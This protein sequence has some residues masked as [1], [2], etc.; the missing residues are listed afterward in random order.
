MEIAVFGGGCFWCTEAVFQRLKGVISVVSGYA[1]GYK[2]NP[3]YQEVSYEETGHAE[4]VKIEFDPS[5]ISY[6]QLLEVFFYVHDPTTLNQQGN[7]VGT[8]YRSIIL[9]TSDEHKRQAE[10]TLKTMQNKYNQQNIPKRVVTEIKP[11]T[12][13]YA[14]EEYHQQYFENNPNQP[15]CQLI[16]GPKLEHFEMMFSNLLKK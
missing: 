16:I 13:F 10:L 6:T 5:I 11:F 15:Y 14:A 2:E 4:V 1:G 9:Y 8:Q 12:N 3:T 7:D